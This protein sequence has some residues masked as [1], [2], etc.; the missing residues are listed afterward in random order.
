MIDLTIELSDGFTTLPL[1]WPRVRLLDFILHGSLLTAS[2]FKDPC[3]G[4]EAKI[5]YLPD[6]S[7]THVDATCHFYQGRES[8]EKTRLESLMGQAVL[9]DVSFKQ[10]DEAVTPE[11]LKTALKDRGLSLERGDIA[12]IRCW[13]G[14]RNEEGFVHCKGLSGQSALWL[15]DHQIKCVGIDLNSIDDMSDWAR[16]AHM[17]LLE[18]GIPIIENLVNLDRIQKPRFDFIGLPLK[19][20]GATGSPVRAVA[21]VD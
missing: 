18:E 15:I 5:L 19:V 21:L 8:I 16:S 11:H 4:W 2:R 17:K 12:I 6:H 1:V 10:T 9:I 14:S 3:K 7:G 20:R 13:N